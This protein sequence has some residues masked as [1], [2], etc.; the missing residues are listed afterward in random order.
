[1]GLADLEGGVGWPR[2]VRGAGRG[3]SGGLEGDRT[4]AADGKGHKNIAAKEL[5]L[6]LCEMPIYI[7]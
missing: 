6:F 1:M 7:L 5:M 3:P 2:G 4:T